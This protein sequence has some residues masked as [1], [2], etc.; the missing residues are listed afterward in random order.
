MSR[1]PHPHDAFTAGVRDDRFA[2]AVQDGPAL[3]SLRAKVAAR[4]PRFA[5][6]LSVQIDQMLVVAP[7]T[8]SAGLW[9]SFTDPTVPPQALLAA[10][11]PSGAFGEAVLTPAGWQV[12]RAA[13]CDLV[14]GLGTPDLRC[15]P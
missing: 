10:R 4:Y 14:M 12:T 7:G 6:T 11:S 2:A 3:A 9:V 1:T 5:A 8:V 13:Y 15:P